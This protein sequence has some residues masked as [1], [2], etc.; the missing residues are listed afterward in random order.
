MIASLYSEVKDSSRAVSTT[1]LSWVN[2]AY[3]GAGGGGVQGQTQAV[4]PIQG[5]P[6]RLRQIALRHGVQ[7]PRQAVGRS[8]VPQTSG[9]QS[10]PVVGNR[11][12]LPADAGRQARQ[13]LRGGNGGP[14]AGGGPVT[15]HGERAVLRLQVAGDL[16]LHMGGLH[17]PVPLAQGV[18]LGRRFPPAAAQAHGGQQEPQNHLLHGGTFLSGR[19]SAIPAMFS[20][21]CSLPKKPRRVCRP[22]AANK[23]QS[24]FRGGV[25]V[26]KNTSQSASVEFVRFQRTNYARGRLRIFCFK[27]AKPF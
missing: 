19:L 7:Q 11:Q 13:S 23:V 12:V 27:R 3:S 25:Y 21:Y 24:V 22:Q 8:H 2:S 26:A 1:R 5:L 6:A 10:R 17:I 15:G 20:I 9:G 4:G 18:R 14:G 16:R